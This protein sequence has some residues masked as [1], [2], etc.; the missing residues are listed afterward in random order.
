[1]ADPSGRAEPNPAR[2]NRKLRQTT[3]KGDE[4]IKDVKLRSVRIRIVRPRGTQDNPPEAR[5]VPNSIAL[6]ANCPIWPGGGYPCEKRLTS[7]LFWPWAIS[8][9][10]PPASFALSYGDAPYARGKARGSMRGWLRR[11]LFGAGMILAL[12]Q[13]ASDGIGQFFIARQY[14]R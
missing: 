9:P 11:L 3:R 10:W 13:S 14:R 6:W 7:A 8:P 1:M 5:F 2:K 12:R 4:T